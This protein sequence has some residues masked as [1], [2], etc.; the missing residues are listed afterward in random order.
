MLLS[1]EAVTGLVSRASVL[2]WRDRRFVS[3]LEEWTRFDDRSLDGMTLDCLRLGRMD[4]VAL[5]VALRRRRLPTWLAWLY[6]QHEVRLTRSSAAMAVLTVESR[7]PGALFEC[8]RAL[9][10][11]WTLINAAGY[12]WHPMSVV[13]DQP[14]VTDLVPLVGGLDPVAI[15]R[16][17]RTPKAAAWSKRRTLGTVLVPPP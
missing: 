7:E 5:R 8:G 15:Y 10:R 2:S 9:I 11:S 14:T 17:G 4:R 1:P 13:I 12:S 3:D 6:G 16:V